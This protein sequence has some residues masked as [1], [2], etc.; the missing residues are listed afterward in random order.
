MVVKTKIN[1][2]GIQTE[3]QTRIRNQDKLE[4]KTRTNSNSKTKGKMINNQHQRLRLSYPWHKLTLFLCKRH[5][6]SMERHKDSMECH[7][8]MV[9]ILIILMV[10]TMAGYQEITECKEWV[11][12][13]DSLAHHKDNLV[14]H[15]GR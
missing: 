12:R 8:K 3:D 13:V 10:I 7:S 6:D 11:H 14:Y 2:L 9:I 5:K 15:K 1:F 4:V